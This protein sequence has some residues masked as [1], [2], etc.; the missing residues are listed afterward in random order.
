M[1]PTVIAFLHFLAFASHYLWIAF[2]PDTGGNGN[3]IVYGGNVLDCINVTQHI[4]LIHGV[5]SSGWVAN[6]CI[7]S[8]S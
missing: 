1:T 7:Q 3:H 2:A 8:A 6:H 5:S 4:P